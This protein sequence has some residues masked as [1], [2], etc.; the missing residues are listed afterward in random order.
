[1]HDNAIHDLALAYWSEL[2]SPSKALLS[3]R[4]WRIGKVFAIAVDVQSRLQSSSVANQNDQGNLAE[5]TG[6][7]FRKRDSRHSR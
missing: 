3:K 7:K 2:L 5:N 4:T 6:L 1:M